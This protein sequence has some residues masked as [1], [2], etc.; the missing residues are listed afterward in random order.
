ME[1]LIRR[2]QE[3]SAGNLPSEMYG[4]PRFEPN[5]DPGAVA[6][7]FARPDARELYARF[8]PQNPVL[9]SL[10]GD[11][12]LYSFASLDKEQAGYAFDGKTREPV[13][14]WP[15]GMLVIGECSA[16]PIT[17]NPAEPGEVFFA[18]HG[19]GEWSPLPI[20]PDIEGFL[21]LCIAWL[22]ME[23]QRGDALYDDTEELQEASWNL[24]VQLAL[25]A[26]I[27]QRYIRNV[28]ELA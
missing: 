16:D 15:E 5:P 14:D 20:A 7:R 21:K 2:I 23:R 9:A 24:F 18:M 12:S 19:Q 8:D 4:P 1:E 6:A 26:G 11:M 28:A 22:D 10:W 25:S 17:L 27:D 13:E 3:L